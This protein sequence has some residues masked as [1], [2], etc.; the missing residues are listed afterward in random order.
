MGSLTMK[1]V[2]AF[3][4]R[5]GQVLPPTPIAPSKKRVKREHPLVARLNALLAPYGWQCDLYRWPCEDERSPRNTAA[6]CATMNA[7]VAWRVGQIRHVG[8]LWEIEAMS[9]EAIVAQVVGK[10]E[11]A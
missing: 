6:T 11:V 3:M 10:R 5:T 9:D 7:I 1:D 2:E 4:K 8:W